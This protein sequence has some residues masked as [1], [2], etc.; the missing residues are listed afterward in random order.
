MTRSRNTSK[1]TQ[2]FLGESLHEFV[3][4][5]AWPP[6]SPD[7]N[8]LDY[9]VWNALSTR[10]YKGRTAKFQTMAALKQRI[11]EAWDEIPQDEIR[12]AVYQFRDRVKTVIREK[13]GGIKQFFS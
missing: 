1:K 3:P 12:R 8:P 4:P 13:G 11:L 2:A 6:N 9:Y 10:V 7:L 5:S